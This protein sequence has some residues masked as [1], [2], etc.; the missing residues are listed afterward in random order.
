MEKRERLRE[1]KKKY[2]N[3]DF[4]ESSIKKRYTAK[5]Q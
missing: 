2:M 3:K 4:R 5:E 1:I